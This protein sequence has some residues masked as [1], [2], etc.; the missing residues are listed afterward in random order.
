MS[1]WC[2]KFEVVEH[3]GITKTAHEWAEYKGVAWETVKKRVQRGHGWKKA[4]EL[5]DSEL[6]NKQPNSCRNKKR[7][8]TSNRA[9]CYFT[10]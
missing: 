1:Y 6:S 7:K 9:W 8:R 10:K 3:K 5:N 4:L 2:S